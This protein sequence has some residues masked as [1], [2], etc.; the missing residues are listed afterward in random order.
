MLCDVFDAEVLSET[1][2]AAIVSMVGGEVVGGIDDKETVEGMVEDP[3]AASVFRSALFETET[4]TTS[5]GILSRLLA[6]PIA[7]FIAREN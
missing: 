4:E 6:E 7:S 1:T 3:G 5:G 2:V